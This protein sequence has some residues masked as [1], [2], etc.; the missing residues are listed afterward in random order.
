MAHSQALFGV[1]SPWACPGWQ[2]PLCGLLHPTPPIPAACFLLKAVDVSFLVNFILS[3]C[4][5]IRPLKIWIRFWSFRKG[6]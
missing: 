2:G 4:S 1:K 6:D 5:M 3:V